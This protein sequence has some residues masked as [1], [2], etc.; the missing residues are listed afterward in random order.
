MKLIKNYIKLKKIN[1]IQTYTAKSSSK[2]NF[3][4]IKDLALNNAPATILITMSTICGADMTHL[5]IFDI[6]LIINIPNIVFLAPTNKE[7]LL[8]MLEWS[9]EQKEHPVA[10]KIPSSDV[11]STGVKDETNYSILNK[12]K[13]EQQGE[14]VAIIGAGKFFELAKE[15]KQE[16]KEKLNIDATLIN[17]RFLSGLDEDMLKGL[18]ETH[19]IVITLEDGCLAGGFGEKISSF[20]SNTEMKVLNYGATKEF[21]DRIPTEEL[22][23]MFRLTK[24]Q[25]REDVEKIIK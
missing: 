13:I 9:I 18:R 22:Y 24:E 1:L 16:I 12:F 7:E 8:S 11:I 5:G 17:P 4:L 25:I 6:P 15:V 19:E 20:Y 2:G 14:K 21:T 3:F 23:K 10:I